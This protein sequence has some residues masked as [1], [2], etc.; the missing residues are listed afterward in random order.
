MVFRMLCCRRHRSGLYLLVL[1]LD[2]PN[3]S[4]NKLTNTDSVAEQE[5]TSQAYFEE[6]LQEVINDVNVVAHANSTQACA[7]F[8]CNNSL[9][10]V[11]GLCA[12][13]T[14]S[15]ILVLIYELFNHHYGI[16]DRP[17]QA[18]VLI[19]WG[20][21]SLGGKVAAVTL[22][23]HFILSPNNPRSP[24]FIAVLTLLGQASLL[25][26]LLASAH[27]DVLLLLLV[28]SSFVGSMPGPIIHTLLLCTNSPRLRGTV[29]GLLE[30]A[31]NVGYT[32]GPVI[33]TAV[34][35][36]FHNVAHILAVFTVGWTVAALCMSQLKCVGIR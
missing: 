17:Q 6:E 11:Q 35:P 8:T 26:S 23:E 4:N 15:A 14:W 20:I 13:T 27:V 32:L 1:L 24:F 9:I 10:Y 29:S 31:D 22:A 12:C 21:C 30:L 7:S 3:D 5:T 2:R 28:T 36:H 33:L 34:L 18:I 16:T 19:I 25:L